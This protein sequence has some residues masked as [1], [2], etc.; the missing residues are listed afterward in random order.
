MQPWR[1]AAEPPEK[2]ELVYINSSERYWWPRRIPFLDQTIILQQQANPDPEIDEQAASNV[3]SMLICFGII[4][5]K[6]ANRVEEIR[7][8]KDRKGVVY[9]RAFGENV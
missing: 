9:R 3:A 8:Y 6:L 4:Y 7:V 5:Y 1:K 2:D